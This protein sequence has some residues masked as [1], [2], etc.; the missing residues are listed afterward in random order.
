MGVY[1]RGP[2]PEGGETVFRVV[3]VHEWIEASYQYTLLGLLRL[4]F[5]DEIDEA[6][7]LGPIK[8]FLGKTHA[9]FETAT[10]R[11]GLPGRLEM[12][13]GDWVERQLRICVNNRVTMLR[14]Q[15]VWAS[16]SPARKIMYV[17]RMVYDAMVR[18]GVVRGFR[19]HG[20]PVPK[21]RPT[22]LVDER[23]NEHVIATHTVPP[24]HSF[25][26]GPL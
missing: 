1:R 18:C 3:R 6:A 2:P 20:M 11:N 4:I 24:V 19:Y 10:F 15:P 25:G 12:G 23:G 16:A 22:V 5:R 9:H 26:P 7:Y 17:S 14:L 21:D 8:L 13:Y